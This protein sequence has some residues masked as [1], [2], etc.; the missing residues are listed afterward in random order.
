LNG[1]VEP[2]ERTV[3]G[4]FIKEYGAIGLSIFG[5]RKSKRS[6]PDILSN[7]LHPKNDLYLYQ[8][9]IK[10]QK[11]EWLKIVRKHKPAVRVSFNFLLSLF[12]FFI[13]KLFSELIK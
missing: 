3:K 13:S 6:H 10:K 7:I 2:L 12:C 9:S 11:I 5:T 8:E 4:L 1:E